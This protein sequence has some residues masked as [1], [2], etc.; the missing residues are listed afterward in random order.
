M[1]LS[2]SGSSAREC[3]IS[4]ACTQSKRAVETKDKFGTL[5]RAKFECQIA[6]CSP[7]FEEPLFVCSMFMLFSPASATVLVDPNSLVVMQN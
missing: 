1:T 2:D 7:H 4:T 6:T 5:A 3:V